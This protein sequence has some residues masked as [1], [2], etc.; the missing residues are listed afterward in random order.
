[1]VT[2]TITGS[3]LT[4]PLRADAN[5]QAF[6]QVQ[7][8]DLQG[9][10]V[11]STLT[12]NV[13][14]VND[15]PR[16][17]T[18]I[19]NVTMSEDDAP[20]DVQ[21]TPTNFFDPDTVNGDNLTLSL[22]SNSNA[23]VVTPT[24]IAGGVRLTL[25][26]N[27]SGSSTIT[28]RATDN[29]G[30]AVTASFVLTVNPV[31][32][33]PTAVADTYTVPQGSTLVANDARGTNAIAGDNG[34]LANDTDVEGNALTATIVQQ[35]LFGTLTFNTDGTF[36]Y[37]HTGT[38]RTADTF[39][40]RASDGNAQSAVTTVTITVGAPI[41]PTHQNAIN[42][43]DV[44]ADGFVSAIDALLIINRLNTVGPGPVSALG[45]PPP[46]LD[47][48]GDNQISSFDALLV[49]NQLN[50]GGSAEGELVA[51]G[52]SNLDAL[53]SASAFQYCV[54]RV[55][56]NQSIKLSSIPVIAGEE[57]GPIQAHELGLA[58]AMDDLQF[59]A[60]DLA[61]GWPSV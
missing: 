38:T 42:N 1:M 56:D 54:S 33:A 15:A 27:Q 23:L 13:V 17:V 29:T 21:L 30:Q 44:N 6:V 51:E 9:Q 8:R 24:I 37:R 43:A 49:I 32:D 16:L 45:S 46:F 14:P 7:A 52:E 36:T 5:G 20:R 3:T 61:Y 57:F 22:V 35:P 19:P 11:V 12:L 59:G 34:V 25:V 47:V 41:P 55:N 4:L 39:T 10:T 50:G 58:A 48:S 26:A 18:A 60:G 28:V 2:P 53:A 31:N 40:Y